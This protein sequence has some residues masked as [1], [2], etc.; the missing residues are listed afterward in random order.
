MIYIYIYIH[1]HNI[2]LSNIYI[3]IYIYIFHLYIE[4]EGCLAKVEECATGRADRER[5]LKDA[6]ARTLP[7]SG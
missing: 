5:I 3:Y 2:S 4:A 1:T 6:Q 7:G